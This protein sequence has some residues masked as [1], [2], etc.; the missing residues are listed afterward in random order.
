MKTIIASTD[1]SE[2]SLNAVNYAADMAVD[3]KARL[4]LLHIV[5]LPAATVAEFPV[6]DI[7]YQD[8]SRESEL[9]QLKS[10]LDERVKK[11]VTIET[12]Q[13]L[14]NINY[15]LKQTCKEVKPFAV[16]MSTHAP[17]AIDRFLFGSKTLFTAKHLEYP[18][19]NVPPNTVYH[20][21]KKIGLATDFK[22]IYH[23]PVED[24][25]SVARA[26]SATLELAFVGKSESE[27]KAVETEKNLLVNRLREFKPAFRFV[28]SD[29]IDTGLELFAKENQ[30]DLVLVV[31][32]KH[33]LFHKSLSQQVIFHLPVPAMTIHED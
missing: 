11:G 18:V 14:G 9:K 7:T 4:L 28:S 32:R 17:G 22:D 16:V 13:V 25:K 6:T 23:L 26:F 5:E 33:G 30:I 21:I 31:P 24:I 10:E 29:T 19:I 15:Q 1:F 2:S 3:I 27:L 12:L 8:V 20:S